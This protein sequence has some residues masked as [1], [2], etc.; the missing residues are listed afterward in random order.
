[1]SR[2]LDAVA[3]TAYLAAHHDELAVVPR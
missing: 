1:M 2:P 3:A